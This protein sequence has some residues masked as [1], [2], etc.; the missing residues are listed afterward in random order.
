MPIPAFYPTPSPRLRPAIR[1]LVC[2]AVLVLVGAVPAA[3]EGQ[4]LADPLVPKG[5]VRLDFTPSVSSWD[6]RYGLRFEDGKRVEEEESLASDVTDPRG[7][8]L[9]PGVATLQDAIRN[10]SGDPSFQASLGSTSGRISKE[11]TRLDMGLRLGLFDWLTVGAN[12]PYVKGRTTLDLAFRPTESANLG[13]NPAFTGSE[14]FSDLLTGLGNAAVAA[15]E[16]AQSVCAGGA[17]GAC[18]SAQ[19][20]SQQANDFWQGLLGAYFAS[21]FFPLASSDVAGRLQ[22]ALASLDAALTSAGLAPVGAGVAFA[23][24]PLD[25][26]TFAS[27][28]SAASLGIAGAPLQG[29]DGLWQMGDV[30]VNATLRLLQGEVRDSGATSPRLAYGLYGGFLVRL[31]TGKLDSP[32]VF[33]DLPSGD[34]QMDLE[35]RV[36]AMVRW[37]A[38]L[39]ARGSFRYGTQGAVD[40]VRRVA[41]HEALLPQQSSTRALTWTPGSYTLLE[42]SPRFFLGEALALSADYRR[43]HKAA[44][45]FTI[46]G[47]EAA[48]QGVDVSVLVDESE[49]TLQELAVGLRYS[50]LALWRQGRVGTPVELGLR[51]IRPLSGAGGQTPKADRVEFS[52]SLFRRIWG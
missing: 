29:E 35:G 28:P 10:L 19:A 32:D 37:G 12:V 18:S 43:F 31:G 8:S 48:A 34:G 51:V 46:L 6:S 41:P 36:D 23:S 49:V 39:G 50:S 1:T 38:H 15:G 17:G 30:E 2:G 52:I 27:L 25:G 24:E 47:D 42:L 26:E 21:P 9:F 33:L 45:G 3:L 40:I 16:R 20:L 44:D 14:G 13:L 22:G 5:R 4:A 11:V 7:V